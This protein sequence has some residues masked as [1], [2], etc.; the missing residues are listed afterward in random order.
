MI[1]DRKLDVLKAIV[2]DY[3]SS[4]EPVGSKAL[5]ERHHMKVSPATVRN[6]MA[7]LEEEGYLTQP[8]T[9]AGRIPTDKGYRL[10]V[11]RIAQVK[12]LSAAE[13][14]AISTFLDGAVDLDDIVSR[15]VRLLAMVTHQVALV[16]Y[17]AVSS[18]RVRHVELVSLA[19]RTIMVILITSVGAIY[20][21]SLQVPEHSAE[22]LTVLRERINATVDAQ[23][24]PAAA[25]AL[26]GLDRQ[27]LPD[28]TEDIITVIAD[29][30]VAD[31]APRIAVGGV[32]NL[33]RFGAEFETTVKPMLEALEEQVVLLK[34]L[35]AAAAE[36]PGDVAVRIGQE[37]PYAP[38]RTASVVASSYGPSD[39]P[40]HLGIVGPTR[41]DYPSTMATVRAVARYVGQFL[42]EG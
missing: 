30:L 3:V 10:F 2:T 21:R 35:G 38:L 41:M 40:A 8:H 42:T 37:N 28:L 6:D 16:Q 25:E 5:V 26:R 11:D 22:D 36:L 4:R 12:P 31:A 27:G 15:T 24:T 34:L 29:M 18:T 39:S 20:Q 19:P 7:A 13:R 32:P 17:P 33:S 23:P 14:R 9:S 1:D